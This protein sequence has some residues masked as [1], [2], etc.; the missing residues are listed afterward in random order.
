VAQL[1]KDPLRGF[2]KRILGIE[3]VEVFLELPC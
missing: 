2:V 1:G 3:A